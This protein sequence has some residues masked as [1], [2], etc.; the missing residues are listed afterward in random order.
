MQYDILRDVLII[1]VSIIAVLAALIGGLVFFIL[2]AALTKDITTKVIKQ[3][4]RECR[5][6]RGQS[7][8]QAGITYWM[9]HLY[10]NAIEVTKQ[11]LA[12]TGDV[13]TE[14]ELIFA[15]SNLGYYYAEKHKQQPSWDLK[16]EA[17]D[18][19]KIGFERYSP[20]I[21]GFQK[22]D[23]IDNFVFVKAV[24]TQTSK[25]REE[26]VQLINELLL[27]GDLATIHAYLEESKQYVLTQDLAQT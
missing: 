27:R 20:S 23:W 19:T 5:K 2:R 12:E 15:K 21:Q 8:T 16:E 14:P 7:K 22:P 17:I 9:Q 4:D 10:D 1:V 24:F 25:E 13:L 6:L 3:V 11:A 18:L 26:V